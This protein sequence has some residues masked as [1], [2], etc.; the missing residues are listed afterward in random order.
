MHKQKFTF[1]KDPK[2]TGLTS[3][4]RPY[5]SVNIKHGK[6]RVGRIFAPNWSSK[7][8]VWTLGFMVTGNTCN[9][10][11]NWM[12]LFPND[13]FSSEQAARDYLKANAEKIISTYDLHHMEED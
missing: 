5:Q 1:K 12:W 7:S 9:P 11:C 4:G 3:V 6:K 10:N 13:T 2:E 8:L